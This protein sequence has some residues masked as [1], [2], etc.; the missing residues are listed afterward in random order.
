MFRLL[1]RIQ[2]KLARTWFAVTFRNT[3]RS[4]G[5]G[6]YLVAPFRLDGA[7]RIEIGTGTFIQR[8]GWLYCGEIDRDYPPLLKLGEH[9]VLGYNN[10]ITCVRSVEIG[11]FVLTANNVYI[12]DNSH[13]Y[14][15]VAR[16]IMQQP[17]VFKGPV[18]IGEGS[19]IGENV[20]I[21]G[22]SIGRNCVIGAN[23]V[24]THDVPDYAVAVGVPA[25]VIRQYDPDS[26][27]WIRNFAESQVA[28][29]DN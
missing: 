11:D 13:G 4:L 19:W 9:C 14:E 2:E 15:D 21:I 17:V 20:S 16:P 10:H 22:A 3:F 29:A 5:S 7:E 25:R 6:A 28:Q 18:S 24:V 23:S 1:A 27:C 8:G 26:R 12:S